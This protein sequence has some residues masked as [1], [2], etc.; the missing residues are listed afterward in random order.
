MQPVAGRGDRLRGM[1]ISRQPHLG[2]LPGLEVLS[3]VEVMGSIELLTISKAT[4]CSEGDP[5]NRFNI[6]LPWLRSLPASSKL[7]ESSTTKPSSYLIAKGLLTLPMGT[8]NKAWNREYINMEE[9]LPT[10][11]SLRLAEL[12]RPAVSLQ[13]SLVGALNYPATEGT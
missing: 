6:I 3:P 1:L 2:A 13:E 8:V 4:V 7:R 12:T 10:P 5:T 11:R 9:F